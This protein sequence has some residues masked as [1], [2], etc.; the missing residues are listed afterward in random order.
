[1]NCSPL[2]MRAAPHSPGE[3]RRRR[4][5]QSFSSGACSIHLTTDA[6]TTDKWDNWRR[7]ECCIRVQM[8]DR[9]AFGLFVSHLR[10]PDLSPVKPRTSS[11]VAEFKMKGRINTAMFTREA[12]GWVNNGSGLFPPDSRCVS[13]P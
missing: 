5:G 4:R 10:D 2:R 12:A 7:R 6:S 1:M 13:L 3:R 11:T 9:P 8:C